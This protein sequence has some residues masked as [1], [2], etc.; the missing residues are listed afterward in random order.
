MSNNLISSLGHVI[1]RGIPFLTPC[2]TLQWNKPLATTT[3]Q[4]LRYALKL[5]HWL[6]KSYIIQGWHDRVTPK[7]VSWSPS[8]KTRW[9]IA[10]IVINRRSPRREPVARRH[11]HISLCRQHAESLRCAR[12][13]KNAASVHTSPEGDDVNWSAVS[14]YVIST[15]FFRVKVLTFLPIWVS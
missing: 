12:V 1:K 13:G 6:Y 15:N 10:V 8:D 2:Q 11:S 4:W 5:F 14:Q 3:S 7:M 9:A